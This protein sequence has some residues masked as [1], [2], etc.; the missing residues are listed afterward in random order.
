MRLPRPNAGSAWVA[1]L[2]AAVPF[3]FLWDFLLLKKVFFYFDFEVQWIPI[4]D[5]VRTSLARGESILWNPYVML[6]FP[7]HAES[8][9]GNFYPPNLL[10]HLLPR[11]EYA[12]ALSLYAHLT[13]AFWAAWRLARACR[14]DVVPALFAALGFAF[15]GYMFAQGDNY[16]TVLAGAYLPFKLLL[17]TWYFQ[18]DN[19][20]YLLYF[21]L[22]LGIE[23]LICHANLTFITTFAASVYFLALAVRRRTAAARDLAF[24]T[25]A[26]LLAAL[27][28]AVQIVP[29]YELTAQSWRAGGMDYGS[30]T[31]F[32]LSFAQ[33][34]TA[35]F[36]MMYGV[37]SIGY[38]GQDYFQELYF[39]V[40]IFGI[41]LGL[42]G[43]WRLLQRR[44]NRYLAA[45]AL[46]GL[47]GFLLS[48]G[49]NNP[50]D[51]FRLLVHVPGFNFFRVPARWSVVL[52]L[53]LAM[54]AGYGLQALTAE[55]K[56]GKRW[57]ALAVM[58]G[59][60]VT[61]PLA[62]YDL[63][64]RESVDNAALL[65]K[66]IQ[67]LN[68]HLDHLQAD[69]RFMY[70]ALTRISPLAYLL[71][72]MLL[73][74]A[75]VVASVRLPARHC[76]LAILV[77]G[78]LDLLFVLRP[79]NPRAD[80]GFFLTEPWHIRYLQQNAGVYRAISSYE[81]PNLESVNHYSGA[82]HRVQSPKGYAPIKLKNYI[83]IEGLVE[84]HRPDILDYIGVKYEIV[85]NWDGTFRVQERRDVFPRAFLLDRYAVAADDSNAFE[86]FANMDRESRKSHAVI[87]AASARALGL[88]DSAGTI[89][90]GASA[91]GVQP[92]EITDYRHA[93]VEMRAVTEQP[94]FLILTDMYY[95]GWRARVNDRETPIVPV[96]GIFRGVYLDGPGSF[97]IEMSYEPLSFKIG[98]ACSMLGLILLAMAGFRIW[99]RWPLGYAARVESGHLRLPRRSPQ[100][101]RCRN[102]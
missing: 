2:I 83:A 50:I 20:R 73:L 82:F 97:E 3:V 84:E 5:F 22:L 77:I 28:A 48:L 86:V 18:R 36:P 62:V 57:Q 24:F 93:R 43:A 60:S 91:A 37:N 76:A 95:P 38:S 42:F 19:P 33:Y 65:D 46:V 72:M 64:L 96:Q 47:V 78:V 61:M 58:L 13:L 8:Q 80:P 7:Q 39:Y 69:E 71:C 92:V 85:P 1:L 32:S 31:S 14:L 94:A 49:S 44:D 27:I 34:L 101:Y 51:I 41:V 16:N 66:I 9:V 6:G 87:S 30:M 59:I 21:A 75:V 99:R 17:I 100:I 67:P 79:L 102:Y 25:L 15:S 55:L 90:E 35:F 45:L 70:T 11:Q 89:D 88:A 53:G 81:V 40:G 12:I 4:H 74:A 56:T 29:T 26:T 98:A 10:L 68:A 52:T 23:L 54:L 63:S